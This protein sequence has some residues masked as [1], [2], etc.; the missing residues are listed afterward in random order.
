[1]IKEIPASHIAANPQTLYVVKQYTLMVKQDDKKCVCVIVL[2]SFLLSRLNRKR[3]FN[4][5][6]MEKNWMIYCLCVG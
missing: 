3:F 5:G 6:Q 1:M 4:V 2:E